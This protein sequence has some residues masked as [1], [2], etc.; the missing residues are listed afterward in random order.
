MWILFE[1]AFLGF[2]PSILVFAGPGGEMTWSG[3]ETDVGIGQDEVAECVGG[4][5]YRLLTPI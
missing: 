2:V 3:G 4:H 5:S 1:R